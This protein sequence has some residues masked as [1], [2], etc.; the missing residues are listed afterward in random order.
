MDPAL[1]EAH[2]GMKVLTIEEF[3]SLNK[4]LEESRG[5]IRDMNAKVQQKFS[6]V[7]KAQS[8]LQNMKSEIAELKK[9]TE[10]EG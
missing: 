1:I 9:F 7:L 6:E 4:D 5:K 3:E 8:T 2:T 10:A